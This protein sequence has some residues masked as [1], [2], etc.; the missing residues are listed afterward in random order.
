MLRSLWKQTATQTI[1]RKART[2]RDQVRRRFVDSARRSL[3]LKE[4]KSSIICK[5]LFF[6]GSWRRVNAI[7]L[8]L[9]CHSNGALETLKKH[10]MAAPTV[11]CAQCSKL[12]DSRMC[13]WGSHCESCQPPFLSVQHRVRSSNKWPNISVQARLL[14]ANINRAVA[15]PPRWTIISQESALECPPPPD[16]HHPDSPRAVPWCD[17]RVCIRACCSLS[18]QRQHIHSRSLFSL[19]SPP[20]PYTCLCTRCGVFRRRR[21][22]DDNTTVTWEKETFTE[23]EKTHIH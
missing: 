7:R 11:E 14:F 21:L 15:L 9:C 23:V 8:V 4:S 19:L 20:Q 1:L 13:A 10:C 22:P 5:L 16:A 17:W 2:S 18:G 12:D 3:T 6:R